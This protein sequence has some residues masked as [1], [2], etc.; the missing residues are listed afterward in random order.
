MLSSEMATSCQVF[1]P[2]LRR[3]EGHQLHQ[4]SR[5]GDRCCLR[6]R[7]L[8][9]TVP[10]G[11]APTDTRKA[12]GRVG[13]RISAEGQREA[14]ALLSICIKVW[15]KDA[16]V[17]SQHECMPESASQRLQTTSSRATPSATPL[18]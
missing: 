15:F 13:H 14:V 5:K 1:V 11:A 6:V 12:R 7:R 10:V 16:C 8:E 9:N 2:G 3:E 4:A 18:H 17:V